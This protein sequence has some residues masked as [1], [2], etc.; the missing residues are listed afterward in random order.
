MCLGVPAEIIAIEDSESQT[1]TVEVS[2]VRRRVS[3]ACVL[4]E[5][6]EPELLVGKWV[7]VHVGFA[8]S[9]IDTD[10]AHRTLALLAELESLA[11][12][13]GSTGG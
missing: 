11:E 6:A 4:A 5:G 2:G 3:L 10:E 1:A 13:D 7:L 8:M 9:L 12:D